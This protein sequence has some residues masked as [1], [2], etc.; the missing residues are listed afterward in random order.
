[1]PFYWGPEPVYPFTAGVFT[2]VDPS[3]LMLT[4]LTLT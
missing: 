2:R 4:L 1:M 3:D